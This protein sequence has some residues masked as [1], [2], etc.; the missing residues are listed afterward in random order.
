MVDG[1]P[2]NTWFLRV[3]LI[4][5]LSASAGC[6][7]DSSIKLTQPRETPVATLTPP[8]EQQ[9]GSRPTATATPLDREEISSPYQMNRLRDLVAS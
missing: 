3:L 8:G 1:T 9:R 4:A 7:S 6:G 5:A 2:I